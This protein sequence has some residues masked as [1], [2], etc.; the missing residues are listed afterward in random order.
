V[1]AYCRCLDKRNS[2]GSLRGSANF[3]HLFFWRGRI[4]KSYWSGQPI[5]PAKYLYGVLVPWTALEFGG[6]ISLLGCFVDQALLP[7]LL[8][9]LLAFMFYVT[10]W[11][12]GRSMVRSMGDAEDAGLYEA[13]R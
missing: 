4:F 3:G 5:A 10:L 13:P 7:N 8:P 6:I 12:S 1:A 9:A 11:P 2:S